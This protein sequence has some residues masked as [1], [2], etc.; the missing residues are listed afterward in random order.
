MRK[1]FKDFIEIPEELAKCAKKNEN[2][3]LETKKVQNDCYKKAGK[4][5]EILY[6]KKCAYCEQKY[7]ST[8]DTWVE[9]YRPKAKE[10]YYWLAYEWSN[11]LPTCTKCNRKKRTQFPLLSEE[12]RVKA[13][14]LNNHRLDKEKCKADSSELLNES[15]LVLH[16]EIDEPE[17]FLSFKID[18]NKEG[19]EICEKD[20]SNKGKKTIEVCDL[21]RVDLKLKR[22]EIVIDSLVRLFD[23]IIELKIN[24]IISDKNFQTAFNIVY[25]QMLEDSNNLELEHTLLRRSLIKPEIFETLICPFFENKSQKKIIIKAIKEIS[26]N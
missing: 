7:L 8:S 25:K 12:N 9:H 14:L 1:V 23:T 22:Q 17:M 19:V 20:N 3:L 6:Y 2:L 15:A 18:E 10:H 4:Q 5:L 26:N 13:P 16:P 24:N 21:N 11:L